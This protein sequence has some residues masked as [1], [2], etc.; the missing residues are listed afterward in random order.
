MRI[1]AYVI[2]ENHMHVIASSDSLSEEIRKFKS[3]TARSIIDF[4]KQKSD[5]EILKK[6]SLLKR[7]Y[8]KDRAYQFWQEGSHPQQ[9]GSLEM[10]QQ[11]VD[12]IHYNPVRSGH[13]EEPEEW[14]YSS[15][16][17]YAGMEGLIDVSLE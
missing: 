2:M 13:V 12:Y 8:K 14:Q 6:L 3:F 4:Y 15:A 16:K 9:I 11:K 5:S 17:N 7:T 10:M 1:F